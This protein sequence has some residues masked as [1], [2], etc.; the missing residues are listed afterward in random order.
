M[1]VTCVYHNET[2]A[3]LP[4]LLR[5]YLAP[6]HITC[7]TSPTHF[8]PKFFPHSFALPSFFFICY[9]PLP[10]PFHFSF[11]FNFIHLHIISLSFLFFPFLYYYFS[12]LCFLVFPLY[13]FTHYLFLLVWYLFS[14]SSVYLFTFPPLPFHPG[15]AFLP[16][17][18]C[19][20]LSTILSLYLPPLSLLF[21]LSLRS[22]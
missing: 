7:I 9:I 14:P 3:H 15:F 1:P 10:F 8:L 18:L 2:P 6:S 22:P 12:F 20:L 17:F 16:P 21:S 19:I 5:V 4:R 13:S 11:I